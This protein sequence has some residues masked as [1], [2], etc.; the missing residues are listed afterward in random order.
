MFLWCKNAAK[1]IK[2]KQ[3]KNTAVPLKL[4]DYYDYYHHCYYHLFIYLR[5]DSE[6][7]QATLKAGYITTEYQRIFH[8]FAFY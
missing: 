5:V 2:K 7:R 8:A 4:V 6:L 3:K 1:K